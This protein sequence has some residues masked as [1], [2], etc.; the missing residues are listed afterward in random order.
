MS[1]SKKDFINIA[2]HDASDLEEILFVALKQ[3]SQMAKGRLEPVLEGRTLACIFH[4]PSLRTRVSFEVAMHQLGGNSLYLTDQEIGIGSR[5]APQDVARVL[6]RYVSAIMIRT[7]DQAIV[8]TLAK[9]ASVPVIN[10]LTDLLHPCQIMADLLTI[11]ERRHN[12]DNLTVA[13]IGDG[14]NVSRSWLNAAAKLDFRFVLACPKGY[15]LD[16]DFVSGALGGKDL[17]REIND[18]REA[19][20]EAD[21]LYTDVWTSMG[22]EA[23]AAKRKADFADFQLNQQLLDA[24]PSHAIVLHC[25]PAHRGEEITDEVIESERSLVFDQA[26]NRLHVQRALLSILIKP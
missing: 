7:F 10:G 26:E 3:K 14:N 23:D 19:V 18:P 24:A 2:E 4:K 8:E 5:E 21:V 6:S 15:A 25:L 11:R 17:Y 16:P 22:Q 12:L 20:K 1:F 9:H 13:F